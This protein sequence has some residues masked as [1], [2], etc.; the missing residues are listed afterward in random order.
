MHRII[1]DDDGGVVAIANFVLENGRKREDGL[2]F[3]K[4]VV[5]Q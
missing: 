3:S 2:I 5:V 4:T 1:T